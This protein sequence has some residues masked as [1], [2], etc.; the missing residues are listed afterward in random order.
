LIERQDILNRMLFLVPKCI[1][2]PFPK[3]FLK[4]G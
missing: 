4:I 1:K 2:F 3:I